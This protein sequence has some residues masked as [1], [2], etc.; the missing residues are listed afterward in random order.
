MDAHQGSD[1]VIHKSPNSSQEP[2]LRGAWR[3]WADVLRRHHMGG[4]A[5]FFLEAGRP[6][7]FI[8]AQLL[9]MGQP[10]LGQG[11][12]NL[13]LLLESESESL[14]FIAYLESLPDEDQAMS[15]GED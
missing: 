1:A 5:A 2:L 13:A 3:R 10:F 9:H 15:R 4:V 14:Q 11:A 7:T 12:G 8:S 6:L